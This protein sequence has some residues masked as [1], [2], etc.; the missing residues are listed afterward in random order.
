LVALVVCSACGDRSDSGDQTAHVS[1]LADLHVDYSVL[2]EHARLVLEDEVVT[3][4]EYSSSFDQF[5]K[6]SEAAG[7]DT[8]TWGE[9]DPITG[10]I[11]FGIPTEL[12]DASLRAVPGTP[13]ASCYNEWMPVSDVWDQTDPKMQAEVAQAGMEVFVN[14]DVP[15]L[16]S[17]GVDVP[18][19]IN[20]IDDPRFLTLIAQASKLRE[21][22][23]CPEPDGGSDVAVVTSP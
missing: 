14:E 1:W 16:V 4:A 21:E 3:M 9:V 7:V 23:R 8:S 10:R 12:V 17:N 11:T 18:Q 22:G 5:K 20:S 2:P 15:C 6:C 13:F 19:G